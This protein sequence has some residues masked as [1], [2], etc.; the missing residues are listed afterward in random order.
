MATTEERIARLEASLRRCRIGFL[1]LLLC[2]GAGLVVGAGEASDAEQ[3]AVLQVRELRVVDDNGRVRII[4]N[5]S[6]DEK[7]ASLEM[8]DSEGKTRISLSTMPNGMAALFINDRREEVRYAA[9]VM[10]NGKAIH[11]VQ[12]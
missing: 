5:G 12:K 4:L 1:G 9:A 8:Q 10:E 6:D 7:A 11:E 3:N 2:V